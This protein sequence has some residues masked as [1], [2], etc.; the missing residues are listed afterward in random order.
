MRWTASRSDSARA[1]RESLDRRWPGPC[2]VSSYPRDRPTAR[3]PDRAIATPPNGTTA[4]TSPTITTPPSCTTAL[5]SRSADVFRGAVRGDTTSDAQEDRD[6][7]RPQVWPEGDPQADLQG[8]PGGQPDRLGRGAHL[9]RRARAVPGAAG[10]R[11][12]GRR[13]RPVPADDE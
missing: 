6:Q 3:P 12:P 2:T 11:R 1:S 5:A 7:R 10:P 13:V 9:L 4:P 8:V